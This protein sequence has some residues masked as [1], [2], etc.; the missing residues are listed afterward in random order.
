MKARMVGLTALTLVAHIGPVFGGIAISHHGNANPISEGWI[1]GAGWG[2]QTSTGA[3]TNDMGYDAWRI[4]DQGAVDGQ[5]GHYDYVMSG[6]QVQQAS[7][8]GWS[9]SATLRVV[10]NRGGPTVVWMSLF[11]AVSQL[12]VPI[13][14]GRRRP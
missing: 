11:D 12:S 6:Q 14:R 13:A 5:A 3:V 7:Q 1:Q 9:L 10:D 8:F 4:D 2:A